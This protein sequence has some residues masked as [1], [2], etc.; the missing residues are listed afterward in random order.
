MAWGWGCPQATETPHF[1]GHGTPASR[2]LP[3][4]VFSCDTSFPAPRHVPG[5]GAHRPRDRQAVPSWASMLMTGWQT[6][7]PHSGHRS[8]SPRCVGRLDTQPRAAVHSPT[9]P[10]ATR[11]ASG[12]S[13]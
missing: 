7:V 5:G 10:S 12:P 8:L 1:Q 11:L 6:A 13:A 9:S 4:D 3:H 2:R